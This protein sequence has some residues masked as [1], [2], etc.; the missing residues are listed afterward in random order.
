MRGSPSPALRSSLLGPAYRALIALSSQSVQS[1]EES[2]GAGG[3]R[4]GDL[5][6]GRRARK[7][8]PAAGACAARTRGPSCLWRAALAHGAEVNWADAEDEGKDAAGSGRAGG[9]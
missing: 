2:S 9:K 3:R 8:H 7:L 6:L 1:R 4:G 5:G